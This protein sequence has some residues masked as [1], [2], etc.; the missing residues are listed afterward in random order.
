MVL[1]QSGQLVAAESEITEA[2]KDPRSAQPRSQ[3]FLS[4]AQTWLT[5]QVESPEAG[6]AIAVSRGGLIAEQWHQTWGAWATFDAVRLGHAELAVEQLEHLAADSTDA[7]VQLFADHARACVD[8]DEPALTSIANQWEQAEAI[9]HAAEAHAH[10]ADVSGTPERAAWHRQRALTLQDSCP[11]LSS[12][13]LTQ[14]DSPLT[15][16]EGEVARRAATGQSSRVIAEDLFISPRT[17]DNHL[18]SVYA[19]LGIGGRN[20]LADLLAVTHSAAEAYSTTL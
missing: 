20:E 15:P 19:R 18:R 8:R 11:D 1:A 16:R 13:V 9:A 7:T 5:A 10:A 6:A 3:L 2:L 17:V 4:R 12:P 14:Q